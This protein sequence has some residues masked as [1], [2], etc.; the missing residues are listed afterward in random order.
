[1]AR[2]GINR[3]DDLLAG[4]PV[5]PI[6]AAGDPETVGFIQ[7]L[8]IG[9]DVHG[10]PGVLGAGRG[11]FGPHTTDAVRQFQEARSLPPTGVVD[12]A[13]LDRLARAPWAQPF[14]CCGYVTLVLDLD[15][16]GLVRL[17]S[18]TSQFEGAGRF[19]A[20]NRNS[21][22]AGLSFG[23]IQWAQKPGRLNEL[24]RAFEAAEP[25]AYGRIFGAGN[26]ADARGLID[27][28]ARPRGG[29]DD[30]GRTLDPRFDL[31]APPW[32]ARFIAAGSDPALQRVQIDTAIAAFHKSI[33]R[34]QLFAPRIQ[35]ER[36]IAFMLDLAN[37]HGD[38]GAES[39]FRA[40]DAPGVS[41]QDLLAALQRESVARVRAQFGDGVVVQSTLARREAFRNSPALSD[42]AFVV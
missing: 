19:T 1:M 10:L 15:F 41:D 17:V 12:G 13:T 22:R 9:H 4:R 33:A 38:A 25:A 26:E 37:Q 8:L 27:H 40:A 34:L 21:D 35:S 11:T 39:I 20:L 5:D 3:I 42:E 29:T 36:G 31:I 30:Q 23:L 18:L 24:L 32:D 7:D 28:T 2:T 6:G 16:T 14:A